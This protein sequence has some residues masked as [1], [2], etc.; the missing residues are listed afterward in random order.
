MVVEWRVWVD[1]TPRTTIPF[2]STAYVST[3]A[4]PTGCESGMGWAA[5]REG[6]G[7]GFGVSVSDGWRT[8]QETAMPTRERKERT[9]TVA[10]TDADPLPGLLNLTQVGSVD[11]THVWELASHDQA[12]EE[13]RDEGWN[14]GAHPNAH[15]AS[16]LQLTIT[17]PW[18]GGREIAGHAL[19][20]VATM[21]PKTIN[22]PHKDCIA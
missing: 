21:I 6:G 14:P 8:K 10:T 17:T 20:T 19:S 16:G 18:S 15:S 7:E 4:P 1:V 5:W 13:A 22:I 2:P 11:G 3:A 9:D 12:K